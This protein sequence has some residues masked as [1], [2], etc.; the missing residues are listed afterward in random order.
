MVHSSSVLRPKPRPLVLST[1]HASGPVG[2]G[3][4]L[5]P[6]SHTM[7]TER[8]TA[9]RSLARAEYIEELAP[10]GQVR[11]LPPDRPTRLCYLNQRE[12]VAVE[13]PAPFVARC[14]RAEFMYS[15]AYLD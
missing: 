3:G 2:A 5:Q 11:L 9:Y 10:D 8:P 12:K 13:Q 6:R 14:H 1:K 15:D 7:K 4:K